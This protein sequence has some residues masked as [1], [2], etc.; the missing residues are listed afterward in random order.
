MEK[1]NLNM[2]VYRPFLFLVKANPGINL[3]YKT[4]SDPLYVCVFKMLRDTLYYMKGKKGID[5][6]VINAACSRSILT[7][8]LFSCFFLALQLSFVREV[9]DFVLEQFSSSQSELQRVLHDSAGLSVEHSPLKLRCQ[10]NAACVD[11][12]VWTV[13]DEQGNQLSL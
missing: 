8:D 6:L 1:H 11:L 12:M 3:Y 7:R 2:F 9:H 10:A 4:F 5:L 13:K